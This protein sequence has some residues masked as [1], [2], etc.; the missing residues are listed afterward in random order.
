MGLSKKLDIPWLAHVISMILEWPILEKTSLSVD[1]PRIQQSQL[2][3]QPQEMRQSVS[4][5]RTAGLLDPKMWE[6]LRVTQGCARVN[7]V[8]GTLFWVDS[9]FY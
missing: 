9:R 5:A 1:H 2:R 4:A 6:I 8:S 3:P 7:Q